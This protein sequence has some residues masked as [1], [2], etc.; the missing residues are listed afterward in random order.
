[1]TL[2]V[3]WEKR[4]RA[5]VLCT[6][7]FELLKS[8]PYCALIILKLRNLTTFFVLPMSGNNP[9]SELY[10]CVKSIWDKFVYRAAK[11]RNPNFVCNHP[12]CRQM[13][14]KTPKRK[15]NT[16]CENLY[17]PSSMASHSTDVP[18]SKQTDNSHEDGRLRCPLKR[19][20]N[21]SNWWWYLDGIK[22][23]VIET[24]SNICDFITILKLLLSC[25]C[26]AM[27]TAPYGTFLREL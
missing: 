21:S 8:A 20:P 5:D 15:L 19:G 3:C 11:R 16:S 27:D 17:D 22:P 7:V 26:T 25:V 9:E 6:A 13:S 12:M 23:Y 1:M 24:M 10:T 18:D 14:L 2:G 4:S